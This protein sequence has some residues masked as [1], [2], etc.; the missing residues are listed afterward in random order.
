MQK[1]DIFKEEID[2]QSIKVVAGYLK[3]VNSFCGIPNSNS[4]YV[5]RSLCS[6]VTKKD[7]IAELRLW[8]N[9]NFDCR[10]ESNYSALGD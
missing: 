4:H 10:G 1:V 5:R 7:V 3:P 9:S 8:Q 2:S 6:S